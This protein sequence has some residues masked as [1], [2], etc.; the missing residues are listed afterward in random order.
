M[1]LQ[2]GEI[3]YDPTLAQN[4]TAMAGFTSLTSTMFNAP[5]VS[6]TPIPGSSLVT[7]GANTTLTGSNST[8]DYGYQ[9]SGFAPNVVPSVVPPVQ[10]AAQTT[11]PSVP[12][13]AADTQGM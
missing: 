7:P 10:P 11:Q 2:T 6:T 1:L 9:S 8:L 12:M 5:P 3:Q 13:Y 4:Q